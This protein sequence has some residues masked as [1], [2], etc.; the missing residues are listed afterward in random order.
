MSRRRLSP[1]IGVFLIGFG[2][3]QGYEV[4]KRDRDVE[5]ATRAIEGAR[6]DADRARA[7]DTRGRAYAEKARYSG[8]FKL[9]PPAEYARVFELALKDHAQAIALAPTNAEVYLGRGLTYYWRGTLEDAAAPGT[10]VFWDAAIADFTKAL[11]RDARNAQAIDMRG[12]VR[13]TV[14]DHDGAIAD[15]T[16]EMEVDAS[17]GRSRLADAYC[18]R[19]GVLHMA[20]KAEPAI[21]DYEKSMELGGNSDACECQPENPLVT[22][23]TEKGDYDRSWDVVRRAGA[24]HRFIAPDV[25]EPLVKASGRK[26]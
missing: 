19:A 20:K 15:F 22:L 9:I 5:E 4:K 8:V 13:T 10:K 25:L 11:E 2:C 1:I 21:A 16:R 7:Y 23:Y 17:L 24:A 3:G 18:R 26:Q 14:G 6:S 12:L